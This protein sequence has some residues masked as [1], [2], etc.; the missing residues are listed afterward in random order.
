MIVSVFLKRPH[1]GLFLFLILLFTNL[2]SES[3]NPKINTIEFTG[4]KK[5]LDYIVEREIKHP[6]GISLDSTIANDDRNRI[7]NLGLFSQV[8]W[9]A[10][11]LEDG[12]S[13]LTYFLTESFQRIPPIALPTYE[14]DTGWSLTGFLV[15][16]NYK[17]R[18]QS[19]ILGGSLGGKDTYGLQFNDPWIFGN[20]V[21]M[22]IQF[23]RTLFKHLFLN[24]NLEVNSFNLNFGKW[25]GESL[26]TAFSIELEKKTFLNSI[27][28]KSFHYLTPR[29]LLKYDSR[30]LYWNPSKGILLSQSFKKSVGIDSKRFWLNQ[31]NQSYSIYHS[32]KS[33]DKKTII[34]L[35]TSFNYKWGKIEEVWLDYLG[36]AS[37]VRGWR[38]PDS[39]L[40]YGESQ[41]FRFGHELFYSSLEIRSEIIPKYITSIGVEFGLV[42]VLFSDIGLTALSMKELEDQLPI[43]GSGFGIRIPFP[44]V[45]VLRL[46]YGW[47]GRN[48]KWNSGALHLGVGQKF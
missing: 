4:N 30:D 33:F 36:G 29:V 3:Y 19:L 14:E 40:Y 31:W 38:I 27:E 5:T 45:H 41:N 32:L 44:I 1:Q 2:S 42:F 39:T 37:T 10:I 16:N 26:K 35:N 9:K 7:D 46:D 34:A 47:G 43:Y 25:F 12:S 15:L 13:V 28:K 18:N 17:G 48:N 11:P 23:G 6:I 20:H 8:T 21:S 22:D 24:K